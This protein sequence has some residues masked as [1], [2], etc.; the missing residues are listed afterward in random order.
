ME[1]DVIVRTFPPSHF[2]GDWDKGGSY[3]KTKPY[4]KEMQLGEVDAEI[5]RIEKEEVENA[6]AKVKQFGGFRLEALDVTKLALLRPDGHPGAYMNPFP[7]AN[8]VPKRVQSDCVHWC[9]PW[10]INSWNKIF[11]EMMKKWEKQP[12]SQNDEFLLLIYYTNIFPPHN[13]SY[14]CWWNTNDIFFFIS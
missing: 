12:R 4:R 2:E 6:K 7:F 1:F 10:P 14:F 13:K 5:R 9:L 3:S 11:L 8:G